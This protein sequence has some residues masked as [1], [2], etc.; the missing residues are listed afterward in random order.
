MIRLL[1]VDDETKLLDGLKRSLRSMRHEWD[2]TFVTGGKDALTALEQ[3]PF[4]VVVSDMRMPGMNGAQLLDEV[5]R[6]Y[7][8]I[9]RIVLSGQSDR[10]MIYQSIGASH[11]YL[12]KPCETEHLKATIQ[13]ACAL[14]ELIGNESLRRL[15]AGMR[16]I[17]SQPTLFA[18]IKKEVESETSSLKTIGA[19]IAKDMGMT[20]KVLQLVN[21]AYFG[22]NGAVSTPE[23]AVNLLGL[24]TIQALVLTVHV[25]SQFPKTMEGALFQIDR[26]WA[27]SLETGSLARI[28]AKA[29]KASD[30]EIEQAY[31]AGLLHDVGILVLVANARDRYEATLRT[32]SEECVP[33]WEAEQREFGVTHAEVGAYILG[34]WGLEAPIV[35]VVAF[36]HRPAD[37]PGAAFHPLTAV[38][39]ADALRWE[40]MAPASGGQPSTIDLAYVEKLHLADRLPYWRDLASRLQK[41]TAND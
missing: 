24:D 40:R 22:L 13:R 30:R 16:Q 29:E 7:P 28:L 36:H 18:E 32:A 1:F 20:A 12:A 4:D 26:L 21:S 15:V 38:H 31:T 39:V 41:E 37:Y 34:L 2:M 17:P 14:R 5:Q 3:A 33:V 6:R 10:Q 9:I 27:E 19:I 25:F 35:E 8:Q 23:Q 11:Q